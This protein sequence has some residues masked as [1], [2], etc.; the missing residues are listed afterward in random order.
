MDRRV[1]S[2]ACRRG[3]ERLFCP[4]WTEGGAGPHGPVARN[5]ARSQ[6]LVQASLL[7]EEGVFVYTIALGNPHAKNIQMR[8]DLELLTRVANEFE[9]S[10]P[11]HPRGRSYFAPSVSELRAVFR[12][13]AQDLVVR[14]SH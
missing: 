3:P 6:T 13:V 4:E 12:Q 8:P 1:G 14:L 9:V 10:D 7:R 5:L 2:H 11:D